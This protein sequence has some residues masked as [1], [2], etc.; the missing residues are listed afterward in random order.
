MKGIFFSVTFNKMPNRDVIMQMSA[1]F[2]LVPRVPPP[3][4]KSERRENQPWFGLVM[5]LPDFSRLQINNLGEGQISVM[6]VATEPRGE[7]E[8]L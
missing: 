4:H 5:C 7:W 3:P 8:V 2:N 6:F 1:S